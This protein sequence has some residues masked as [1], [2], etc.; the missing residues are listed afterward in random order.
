MDVF[1]AVEEMG[2]ALED[3]GAYGLGRV[4]ILVYVE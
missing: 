4:W 3:A 1:G 2:C